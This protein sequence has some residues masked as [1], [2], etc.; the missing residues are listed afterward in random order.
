MHVLRLI[1]LMCSLTEESRPRF[2]CVGFTVCGQT[3]SLFVFN[4]TVQSAKPQDA[5]CVLLFRVREGAI[6]QR[7]A[8]TLHH[9]ATIFLAAQLLQ[10]QNSLG[11][12]SAGAPSLP[13]PRSPLLLSLTHPF[14]RCILPPLIHPRT[15]YSRRGMCASAGG[16]ARSCARCSGEEVPK[17][18]VPRSPTRFFPRC[19]GRAFPHCLH[20]RVLRARSTNTVWRNPPARVQI[21]PP[22]SFQSFLIF[23]WSLLKGLLI[24]TSSGPPYSN[25]FRASL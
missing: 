19:A 3:K 15:I 4:D 9:T 16:L 25:I 8:L 7:A 22:P 23:T 2:Y 24:A 18:V 10:P 13:R 21:P 20:S 1:L 5:R 11:A 12:P 17:T 6:S 14:I